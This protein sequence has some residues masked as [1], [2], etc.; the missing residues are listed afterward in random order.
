MSKVFRPQQLPRLRITAS[1]LIGLGC[2]CFANRSLES[3]PVTVNGLPMTVPDGFAAEAVALPPLVERPVA[4][5]FDDKGRLYVTESSGSNASLAEQRK[6]PRHR[7]LR[8]EDTNGDGVYDR[9]TV[10]ADKLMML[11]GIL[12]YRGSV[13]VAAVPEILR[14]TDTD[15]DGIADER[16][17]WHDGG[18]LTGCG[19]DLHGPSLGHDGRLYFTKGGFAS[20]THA[21]PGRPQWTTRAAH[22]FRARPD[23]TEFEPVLTG[24]MDN[25]VDVAFMP[26]GERLLSATFLQRPEAG[27]RDGI[28][29][30]VYGGV[31]GKEHGVLDGHPRTGELLPVLAQLG[32]AAACGLHVHS[33]FGLGPGFRGNAFVCQFNLRSVVRQVLQPVGATYVAREEPFLSVDAVDFHPTDVVEDADGSLLVVDTGG[34]YKLCCPTSQLEKPAVLG[35][36]YRVRRSNPR[37]VLDPDGQSIAW[38]SLTAVDLASLLADRR[39]R[40]VQRATEMLVQIGPAAVPAVVAVLQDEAETDGNGRQAAVWVLTQI[41]TPPSR[42]AVRRALSDAS[43]DVRHA[44]AHS[45]AVTRDAAA[46]MSLA[47]MVQQDTPHVARAAAEAL[48]RIGGEQATSAVLGACRREADRVL[49]HS[50]IFALIEAGEREPLLTAAESPLPRVRRSAL[51]ALDQLPLYHRI[52]DPEA[53]Q[54]RRVL[55][56]ACR[57]DDPSVRDTGLRLISHHAEWAGDLAPDVGGMLAQI[58]EAKSAVP[59]R[60]HEAEQ[61]TG[62]L[63][64]LAVHPAIATAI[65]AACPEAGSQGMDVTVAAFEVMAECRSERV[66]D[67]WITLAQQVIATGSRDRSTFQ[68]AL[69]PFKPDGWGLFLKAL[70]DLRFS[71]KQRERLRPALLALAANPRVSVPQALLALRAA[72]PLKRLPEPVAQRLVKIISSRGDGTSSTESVSPLDRSAAVTIVA[73]GAMPEPL[74]ETVAAAFTELP[75]HDAAVLLPPIIEKGGQ[76]LVRALEQLAASPHPE[77]VPRELLVA[78]VA[79]LPEKHTGLGSKLLGRVD[80]VQ[81]TERQAYQQLVAGLPAG[82]A[83]RGH[84]VFFSNKAACSTCHQLAYA[85]GKVG[86]DLT[87]IGRV[88]TAADLLEAI[89]RPSASFVRSYEPV[90][91]V[92]LGGRVFTGLVKDQTDSELIVQTSATATERIPREAIE[93]LE[94]GTVSLMPKG[95]DRLL[96]PQELADLVA[97]LARTK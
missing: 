34:W 72:G 87:G 42:A 55:L 36:I 17:V 64:R 47:E 6:N 32:P 2:G 27:R 92:T 54:L 38:G 95:Y 19:N 41:E 71:G 59:P 3:A 7:V 25:P 30:A 8:L 89:V 43:P 50:L 26:S 15:G 70:A 48:G 1:L 82:D 12:Y 13:Y 37:P 66:P 52:S 90:A 73:A 45:V 9:R 94:A 31:Y 11:Q 21:V 58:V 4:L 22:V 86:P 24:G 39:P 96:S 63:A 69:L 49:E 16:Q 74:W 35:G 28:V 61:L 93:Q 84:A 56:A 97:F 33:G 81:E 51:V 67:N 68:S 23:G 75:G 65:A 46:M 29:H 5:A 79:A 10:F 83:I 53:E 18:T 76:P 60:L 57:A 88:R 91:V 77:T 20:Q 40:V 14:L 62:R 44:A 80:A 78:A 85:G